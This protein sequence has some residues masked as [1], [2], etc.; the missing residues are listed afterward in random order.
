MCFILLS[1]SN[2]TYDT[3]AIVY[4]YVMKQWYAQYVFLY[5]HGILDHTLRGPIFTV[6]DIR[7]SIELILFIDS[8]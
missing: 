6:L 2:R 7:V 4:G 1:S 3:F 5:P 8:L